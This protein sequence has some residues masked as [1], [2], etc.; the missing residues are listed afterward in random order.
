MSNHRHPHTEA[1][2]AFPSQ[3]YGT[4]DLYHLDDQVLGELKQL[5]EELESLHPIMPKV[6]QE[7]Y[8][9]CPFA[10]DLYRR[11]AELEAKVAEKLAILRNMLPEIERELH[12]CE[13]NLDRI[14]VDA[15]QLRQAVTQRKY[16]ESYSQQEWEYLGVIQRRD[17][18][19]KAL[20]NTEATL[21]SSRRKTHPLVRPG[22]SRPRG[23]PA[24]ASSYP[25][26][27]SPGGIDRELNDLLSL[28]SIPA[29][30]TPNPE[31][32]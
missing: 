16:A 30:R 21:E 9:E 6:D 32:Q 19:M 24:S 2:D 20:Q 26:P 23:L 7:G 29:H 10:E 14:K 31:R 8:S 17:K 15:A 22:D 25:A 4:L 18:V 27:P 28:G 11:K 13:R 5:R 12:R 3:D 1:S